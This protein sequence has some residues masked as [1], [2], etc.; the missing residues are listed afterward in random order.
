MNQSILAAFFDRDGTINVNFGHVYRLQD[1]KFVPGTPELIRGFNR[2]GIPVIVVTNQA[3][4]AK[5]LYSETDMHRFHAYLNQQLEMRYG[6]HIDAY[7]FCPH[8][9]DFT[10][11]CACRKP[12]PGLFFQA[13]EDWQ[14]S[15][16][17]CVMFGDKES[18]RQAAERAGVPRF[19]LIGGSEA[20]TPMIAMDVKRDA[21]GSEK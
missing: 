14:L 4:I 20:E 1:L 18:D 16:D 15:L 21:Y 3:G 11:P 10:G 7:Y 6:A 12:E 5:G 19:Y 2:S 17:D 13:A 9:P 8:H